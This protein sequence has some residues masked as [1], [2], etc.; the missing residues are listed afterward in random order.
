MPEPEFIEMPETIRVNLFRSVLQAQ[1][2]IQTSADNRGI[3]GLS[4]ND[5]KNVGDVGEN[6]GEKS[7]IEGDVKE[8]VLSIISDNKKASASEIAKITSVTQRTVERYI[9]ELREE[10]L[11]IRHGSARGGYWEVVK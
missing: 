1:S 2:D 3:V 9:R 10:G 7:E 5:G 11:L 4:E 8:S 6:V